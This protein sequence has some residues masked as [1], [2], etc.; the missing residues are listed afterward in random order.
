MGITIPQFKV[1]RVYDKDYILIIYYNTKTIPSHLLSFLIKAIHFPNEIA[2]LR[3]KRSPTVFSVVLA[4][5][6]VER[7][8]CDGGLGSLVKE[9]ELNQYSKFPIEMEW[10]ALIYCLCALVYFLFNWLIR[11]SYFCHFSEIIC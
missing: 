10:H 3:T 1:L 6:K 11:I 4:S 8:L 9:L 7:V 2:I 5:L